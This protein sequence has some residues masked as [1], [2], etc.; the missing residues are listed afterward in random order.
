[1]IVDKI[2]KLTNVVRVPVGLVPRSSHF[3]V[4]LLVIIKPFSPQ[5]QVKK[6]NF[7]HLRNLSPPSQKR[8][9]KLI[10]AVKRDQCSGRMRR[11]S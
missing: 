8:K 7:G 10:F 1:M 6:W 11:T 5:D 4:F 9:K 2:W 3:F